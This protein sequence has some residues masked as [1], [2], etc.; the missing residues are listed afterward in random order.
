MSSKPSAAEVL[1]RSFLET[2]SRL[3]DIA[4][5]LDR[6]D[7]APGARVIEAD[8]RLAALRQATAVLFD[9]RPDRAERVQMVFSQPYEEQRRS[10]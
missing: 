6:I 1:N 2:R 9:G 8:P 5:A 10:T 4:A 3:L 7:R